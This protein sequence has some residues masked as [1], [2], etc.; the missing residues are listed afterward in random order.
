MY[1]EQAN[2]ELNV[3]I[4]NYLYQNKQHVFNLKK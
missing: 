4:L 3:N 1:E 2:C